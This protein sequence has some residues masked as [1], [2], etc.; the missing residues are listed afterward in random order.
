MAIRQVG[1]S[2]QNDGNFNQLDLRDEKFH[3]PLMRIETFRGSH[4]NEGAFSVTAAGSSA[5]SITGGDHL[6]SESNHVFRNMFSVGSPEQ[7]EMT[8]EIREGYDENGAW[9]IR[10]RDLGSTSPTFGETMVC[11][12]EPTS[13]GYHVQYQFFAPGKIAARRIPSP[14]QKAV[15]E[16]VP[17][18]ADLAEPVSRLGELDSRIPA[19]DVV[20]PYTAS[21]IDCDAALDEVMTR[22]QSAPFDVWAKNVQQY[23]RFGDFRDK[24]VHDGTNLVGDNPQLAS[25]YLLV[26]SYRASLISMGRIFDPDMKY[27]AAA[28]WTWDSALPVD[29]KPGVYMPFLTAYILNVG[30]YQL[31]LDKVHSDYGGIPMAL[32][33]GSRLENGASHPV[34]YDARRANQSLSEI[35]RLFYT[36]P[37][38]VPQHT[39]ARTTV[40]E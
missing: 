29:P 35:S 28:V 23:E 7:M 3:G 19:V 40:Q 4:P 15:V 22:L 1:Q 5:K 32:K 25:E 26:R 39:V 38:E 20:I 8:L 12:L 36:L 34:V 21:A 9:E 13:N 31:G 24:C 33:P 6:G 18:L 30:V 2:F 11:H 27:G 16:Y 14:L 17:E 37:I 10:A